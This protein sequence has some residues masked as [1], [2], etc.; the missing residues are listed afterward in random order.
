MDALIRKRGL[1][2]SS[3]FRDG[4]DS[5]FQLHRSNKT[6]YFC[7]FVVVFRFVFVDAECAVLAALLAFCGAAPWGGSVSQRW[8][9]ACG[10]VAAPAATK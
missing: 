4:Y 7:F 5:A 9:S 8:R 10:A 3:F 6:N 2:F 1:L